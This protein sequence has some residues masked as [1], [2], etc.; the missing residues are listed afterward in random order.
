MPSLRVSKC[1]D[2]NTYEHFYNS[3]Q[4]ESHKRDDSWIIPTLTVLSIFIT[5][6]IHALRMIFYNY[7]NIYQSYHLIY[8]FNWIV[9]VMLVCVL[10]LF[11]IHVFMNGHYDYTLRH[12][13]IV[14]FIACV[15]INGTILTVLILYYNQYDDYIWYFDRLCNNVLLNN[16]YFQSLCK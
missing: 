7:K 11:I 13:I 5:C 2:K 4:N 14:T 3:L 10:L 6:C 8:L 9:Y 16:K 1:K 15:L 12:N